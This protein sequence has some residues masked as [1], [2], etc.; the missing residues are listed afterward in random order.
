MITYPIAKINIGLLI[1]DKRPDGFH[2]L[3]TI[4]YPIQMQDALEIVEADEFSFSMSGLELDGNPQENLVVKAYELIKNDFN[5]PP[6]KIHLH[7]NIPS[8]AGLGGGSSDAAYALQMLNDLFDLKIEKEK[9]MEYALELGSDCP[10]FLHGKPVF[11]TGRGERMQDVNIEL[12]EYY[13]IMVKPPVHVS[14]KT[15]YENITPQKSRLSLKGLVGFTV[16]KWRGNILNHFERYVFNE[17]PEVGKIK[18]TLYDQGATFALMSGSGSAVYGLFRSEKKGL[19]KY[20]PE[21]Y[22]IYR[23]KI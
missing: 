3:E 4:F 14:T 7:K 18:Q 21:D 11:A 12:K 2:N 19:E 9:L 8:G 20:F 1:T 5:I 10:F 22:K 6:V 17:F 16:G 13:L 15:A 23:Q